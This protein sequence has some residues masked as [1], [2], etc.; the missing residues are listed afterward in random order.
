LNS[1]CDKSSRAI[2]FSLSD[3]FSTAVTATLAFRTAAFNSSNQTSDACNSS[4]AFISACTSLDWRRGYE[5]VNAVQDKNKTKKSLTAINK[6]TTA[7]KIQMEQFFLSE[8][9]P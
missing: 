3:P 4:I 1:A 2:S 8:A 9:S 5:G 6:D 7:L